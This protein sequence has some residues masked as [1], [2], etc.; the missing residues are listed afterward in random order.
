[1]GEEVE[2]SKPEP[3][4]AQQVAAPPQAMPQQP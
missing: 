2:E 4:P 1:M 3:P